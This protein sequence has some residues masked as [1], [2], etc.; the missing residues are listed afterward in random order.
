MSLLLLF[1]GAGTA[2]GNTNPDP[3]NFVF[4]RGRNKRE[5]V[6]ARKKH[7]SIAIRDKRAVVEK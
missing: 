2:I 7:A 6:V 1:H 5:Y 3:D 4:V